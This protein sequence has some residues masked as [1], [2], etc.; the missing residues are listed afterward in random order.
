LFRLPGCY[1]CFSR[2][3]VALDVQPLPA[4][5]NSH[6]TFGSLNN[7]TKLSDATVSLWSRVLEALPDARLLIKSR[8]LDDEQIA[9]K[10]RARF[11]DRGIDAARLDLRGHTSDRTVHLATYNE[12]DIALDTFPYQGVTTT[13][14]ALWMGVPV[15]SMAGDRFVSRNAA[16]LLRAAGLDDWVA[17]DGDAFVAGAVSHAGDLDTLSTQRLRLRD[18]VEAS[19]LLD[20]AGFATSF[21]AAVQRMLD[22]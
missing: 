19:P 11:A 14:E 2:P 4:L 1:L 16:T 20:A 17:A 10:T 22:D 21:L 3:Q 12:M 15:L 5:S 18:Q 7:L 13:A 8:Q 6:L 9:Q